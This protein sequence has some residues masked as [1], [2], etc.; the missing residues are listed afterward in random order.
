MIIRK[1]G[2]VYNLLYYIPNESYRDKLDI[3]DFEV[4]NKWKLTESALG[5]IMSIEV[6]FSIMK[7]VKPVG[8]PDNVLDFF[9]L[10][11]KYNKVRYSIWLPESQITEIDLEYVFTCGD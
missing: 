11:K 7:W 3:L 10:Y 6:H 2:L 1:N 4:G 8:I 5:S 9:G